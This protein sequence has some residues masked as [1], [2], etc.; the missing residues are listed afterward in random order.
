MVQQSWYHSTMFCL[1]RHVQS[2]YCVQVMWLKVLVSQQMVS[3]RSGIL[4]IHG[5]QIIVPYH[6]QTGL[7]MIITSAG[8][9]LYQAFVSSAIKTMDPT[10]CV[11]G[12]LTPSQ[13][14]KLI[15][16]ERCNHVNMKT[17][18]NWIW[19]GHLNVDKSVAN[20]PDP[21]C[22]ACQ[23]GKGH[24]KSHTVPIGS[25][26]DGS[27][28]PGQQVSADQ[29]EAGYPGRIL[30][31]RGLPTPK[32]YKFINMWVD[33]YT[34]YIYLTFHKTKDLASMLASKREAE[35]FA[36]KICCWRSGYQGQQ[37][38][39]CLRRFPSRL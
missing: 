19:K 1:C 39:L 18:N 5:K 26:N 24:N 33:N 11:K 28:S 36:T 35:M 31:T 20:S 17:L 22:I 32:Q 12:N 37:W 29:M 38:C 34:K 23:F 2:I 10:L 9:H 16:H 15:L 6:E 21:I 25:I 13:R 4:T 8:C 7:P 27:T 3:T 14:V 30:T